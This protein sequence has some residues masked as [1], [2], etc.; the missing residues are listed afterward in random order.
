MTN[1]MSRR[2]GHA[3]D[4]VEVA[5]LSS[6]LLRCE[7]LESF[8][9]VTRHGFLRTMRA[10]AGIVCLLIKSGEG[11]RMERMVYSDICP[12]SLRDFNE[13]YICNDP[14]V[15]DVHKR[16]KRAGCAT[17]VTNFTS[18]MSGFRDHPLYDKLYGAYDMGHLTAS[19]VDVAPDR[20]VFCTVWRR[21]ADAPFGEAEAARLTLLSPALSFAARHVI[22]RSD[23]SGVIHS[24]LQALR[25]LAGLSPR[26]TEVVGCLCMGLSDNEIAVRLGVSIRTVNAH[27]A[28][29]FRKAGVS[30]RTR[31]AAYVAKLASA[32]AS[33]LN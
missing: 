7:D 25:W 28:A 2:T 1:A 10:D 17:A 24:G 3:L 15:S 21:A 19:G 31:L 27:T 4:A 32:D 26:E 29:I 18:Q 20:R 13:R 22:A 8:Q 12:D 6:S 30:G 11:W 33:P 16:T 5:A 14:L 9:H 23:A